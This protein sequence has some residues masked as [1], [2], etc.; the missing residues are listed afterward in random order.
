[1]ACICKYRFISQVLQYF[2]LL[3]SEQP[4]FVAGCFFK[5]DFVFFAAVAFIVDGNYESDG[6]CQLF[7]MK[8]PN[9]IPQKLP[10]NLSPSLIRIENRL[11]W[12]VILPAIRCHLRWSF[13]HSSC[14]LYRFICRLFF[15][16]NY[17]LLDLMQ[18]KCVLVF[19][20][21]DLL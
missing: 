8:Q 5:L 3:F 18:P 15:F 2:E 16:Q 11:L 20:F 17:L 12:R 6:I 1:M 19:D 13:I 4:S 10:I 9:Q 21:L 7:L 14:E